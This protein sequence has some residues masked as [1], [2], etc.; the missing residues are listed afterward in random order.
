MGNAGIVNQQIEAAI[1]AS[2]TFYCRIERKPKIEA[3]GAI[4]A[5]GSIQDAEFLSETFR[6]ADAVYMVKKF[7][8]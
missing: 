1:I 2:N 5:I 6:G 3:L 8:G 7:T 4:P